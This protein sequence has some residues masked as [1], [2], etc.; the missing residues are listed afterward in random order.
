MLDALHALPF[1]NGAGRP[2]GAWV[3]LAAIAF[4]LVAVNHWR[5][6]L[7]Y[8]AGRSRSSTRPASGPF[9]SVPTSASPFPEGDLDTTH[10]G[11]GQ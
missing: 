2:T 5:D 11:H 8:A 1:V 7:I 3:V 4:A 9:P 10:Y 6:Q